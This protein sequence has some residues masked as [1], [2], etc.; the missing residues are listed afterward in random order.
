MARLE[1]KSRGLVPLAV[2]G[3]FVLTSVA[4]AACCCCLPPWR[5]LQA[6]WRL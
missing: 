1:Q 3:L 5:W 4:T 2:V 6:C